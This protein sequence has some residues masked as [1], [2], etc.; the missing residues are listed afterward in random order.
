MF[1]VIL[2]YVNIMTVILV[3]TAVSYRYN[4]NVFIWDHFY[5]CKL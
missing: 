1:D 3:W 2:Y 4:A 5:I